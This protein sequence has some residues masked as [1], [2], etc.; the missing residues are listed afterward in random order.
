LS[1]SGSAADQS[2]K[3]ET[4]VETT[5]KLTLIEALQPEIAPFTDQ[6]HVLMLESISKIAD[7]WIEQLTILRKNADAL[8]AQIVASVAK[9]KS[10]LTLLHELGAKVAEEAKRGQEVCKQLSEGI[11][12]IST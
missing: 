11:G 1:G 4:T 10:D 9:T 2:I 5:A 6:V 8:E 3:K 12:K 7:Q